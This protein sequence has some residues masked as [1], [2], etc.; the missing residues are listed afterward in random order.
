MMVGTREAAYEAG[1]RGC[2]KW[3]GLNRGT[4][5]NC[6]NIQRVTSLVFIRTILTFCRDSPQLILRLYYVSSQLSIVGATS[7]TEPT[8]PSGWS[9]S[10][11]ADSGSLSYSR[12]TE[13]YSVRGHKGV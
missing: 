10:Q 5:T 13:N 9:V 3:E 4:L 8:S 6:S 2:A 7:S 1:R 11:I 12:S